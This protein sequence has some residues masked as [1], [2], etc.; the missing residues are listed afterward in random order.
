MAEKDV[1]KMRP[2]GKGQ[3]RPTSNF[4]CDYAKTPNVRAFTYTAGPNF[5]L[6]VNP[7]NPAIRNDAKTYP[8]IL[9]T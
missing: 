5:Y 6:F 7:D 9:C 3:G 2:K 1:F 4:S 8:K